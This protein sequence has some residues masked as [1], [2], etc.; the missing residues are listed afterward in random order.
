MRGYG[1]LSDEAATKVGGIANELAQ[2][3]KQ[4]RGVLEHN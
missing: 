3:V 4:A 1:P 2:L